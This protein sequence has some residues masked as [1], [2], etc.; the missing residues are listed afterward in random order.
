MFS[1]SNSNSHVV[2]SY[3][4]NEQDKSLED[5]LSSAVDTV[6]DIEFAI[7]NFVKS[8]DI[9]SDHIDLYVNGMHIG[10]YM[11]G[12]MQQSLLMAEREVTRIRKLVTKSSIQMSD[13]NRGLLDE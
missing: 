9:L 12:D 13:T 2:G 4:S 7:E 8:M 3:A 6:N 11:Y 1:N 5:R 10:K